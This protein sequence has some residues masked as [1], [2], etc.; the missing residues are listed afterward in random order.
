MACRPHILYTYVDGPVHSHLYPTWPYHYKF[1]LIPYPIMFL[2]LRSFQSIPKS[3]PTY[4]HCLLVSSLTHLPF[5]FRGCAIQHMEKLTNC[6]HRY[7]QIYR[8][9]LQW[10]AEERWPV[11]QK[12]LVSIHSLLW[13]LKS[14]FSFTLTNKTTI[15]YLWALLST[16]TIISFLAKFHEN[17]L[18]PLHFLCLQIWLLFF[19]LLKPTLPQTS[20]KTLQLNSDRFCQRLHL[21][22]LSTSFSILSSLAYMAPMTSSHGSGLVCLS[23]SPES[24]K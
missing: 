13:S 23:C 17:Y 1:A 2:F 18:Y 7:F 3:F 19:S 10:L 15:L 20:V 12:G 14:H 9:H 4:T 6:Q 24:S 5:A 21:S 16:S 8:S 22:T 11:Y